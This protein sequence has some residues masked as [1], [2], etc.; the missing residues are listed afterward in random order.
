MDIDAATGGIFHAVRGDITVSMLILVSSGRGWGVRTA[1]LTSLI[2]SPCGTNIGSN[3]SLRLLS[4][5]TPQC[6]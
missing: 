2:R 3:H 1:K 5:S 6:T 4:D